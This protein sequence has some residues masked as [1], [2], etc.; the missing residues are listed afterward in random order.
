M[1][2]K[3]FQEWYCGE[4]KTYIRFRL[5]MDWDRAVLVV[6][7]LCK[8][9]HQRFIKDGVIMEDGRFSN[10]HPKEEICPPKSAASKDPITK[11][12]K[13]SK[14]GTRDGIVIKSSEDLVRDNYFRERWIEIYGDGSV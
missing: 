1:H 11:K 8:H 6:C 7:P 3:V 2:D 13:D 12:L 5:S 9:E 4:C 10:G 14:W